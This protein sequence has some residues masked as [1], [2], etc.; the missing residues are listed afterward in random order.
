MTMYEQDQV[1]EEVVLAWW[2]GATAGSV[3]RY[4]A[5]LSGVWRQGSA[6]TRG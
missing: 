2:H 4:R 1:E 5:A 6:R 3:L